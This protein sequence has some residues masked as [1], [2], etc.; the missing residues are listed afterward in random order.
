MCPGLEFCPDLGFCP[1]LGGRV[2]PGLGSFLAW[3]FPGL[4]SVLIW[5]LSWSG[6]LSWRVCPDLRGLSWP[7]VLSCL[8]VCPDLGSAGMGSV[9]AWRSPGLGS[10]LA[11]RC[12]VGW[13]NLKLERQI[14]S[15]ERPGS[16][17]GSVQCGAGRG[18]QLLPPDQVPVLS[19]ALVQLVSFI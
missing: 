3:R 9:L 5:D 11:A 15:C 19:V 13:L 10:V 8:R 2:C 12:K 6:V 14:E 17:A 1:G 18:G 7:G 4:G 16:G